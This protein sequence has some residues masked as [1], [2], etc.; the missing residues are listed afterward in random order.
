MSLNIG[1]GELEAMLQGYTRCRLLQ[2]SHYSIERL[3]EDMWVTGSSLD[4]MNQ[5][6]YGLDHLLQGVD[7]LHVN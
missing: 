6:L 1:V 7:L 3:I 2:Y 4:G 5:L